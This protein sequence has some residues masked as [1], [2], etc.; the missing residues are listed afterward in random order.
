MEAEYVKSLISTI[1]YLK[2][3]GIS[4]LFLNEYSS[5]VSTAREA[6]AMGSKFLDAF[7]QSPVRGEVTYD[8]FFWI[9]SDISWTIAD[10]MNMYSSDKD[11]VSGI[12][13]DQFGTPMFAIDTPA[14][15]EISAYKIIT[16]QEYREISSAGFGFICVKQG[17]FENIKR[18]WFETHFSKIHGSN[19]EEF[20]VPL[21]EDFSW[22]RKAQE[23]GY[24]IFL[25]PR[26]QV[27]HHKKVMIFP[28]DLIRNPEL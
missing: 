1:T 15:Q 26:V 11:I 10:F 8:K 21:A 4:Y 22:C 14:G 12:Y 16:E 7:N 28:K 2:D 25:D 23:A 6:T 3:V 27:A 5:A 17:V 13:I 19:G 20:L 18:P 9:D 24:K